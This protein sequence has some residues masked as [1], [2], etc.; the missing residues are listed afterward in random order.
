MEHPHSDTRTLQQAKSAA[1]SLRAAALEQGAPI[2]QAQALERVAHQFGAKDW[3]T[4]R[5]QCIDAPFDHLAA[6]RRVTGRYLSQTFAG[7]ILSM[8]P[9]E[10]GWVQVTVQFDQP[11]DV[12]RSNQFSNWRR[13]V[14]AVI[15]P[16]G[17]S[18]ECTS[19]GQPHM[20]ILM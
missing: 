15:G 13:R 10:R 12:V 4:L 16:K 14:A 20:E 8:V 3:N 19:D 1:K 17:H 18:R 9:Q 7:E 11:V 2:T 5:A 6:G